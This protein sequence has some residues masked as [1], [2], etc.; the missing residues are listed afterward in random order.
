MPTARRARA[1]RL[2]AVASRAP[3]VAV[4]VPT[5]NSA[6]HIDACL[7]SVRLQDPAPEVLAIDNGSADDTRERLA[8]HGVRTITWPRNRGFA[9]AMNAGLSAV[10]TDAVLGLNADTVLELGAVARLCAALAADRSLLGVQPRILQAG[11]EPPRIYSM[12]QWVLPDG[13]AFEADAGELDA[14]G[15]AQCKEVF[16]VCGAACLLRRCETLALGGYE[17]RFFSFYEDV[18]LNLRARAA[19]WRFA[20]ATDAV[21]WHVGNASWR[22]GSASSAF[23]VRLVARNRPLASLKHLPRRRLPAALGAELASLAL[24]IRRGTLSANAGGKFEALHLARTFLAERA[25]ADAEAVI[26]AWLTAPE[27]RARSRRRPVSGFRPV[28]TPRGG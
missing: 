28:P 3:T 24:S 4:I 17:E 19:G 1:R 6:R 14:P 7:A 18:E 25:G 21:V 2:W 13:R 20:C 15:P 16:G 23:N 22:D 10:C 27:V 5:W 9:A 11:T 12:G 8:G 26:E